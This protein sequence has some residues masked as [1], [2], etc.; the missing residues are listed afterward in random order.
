MSHSTI[1]FGPRDRPLIGAIL[2]ADSSDTLDPDAALVAL[3][4]NEGP[5]LVERVDPD[6]ILIESVA[7]EAG[8]PWA[9]SGEPS[10]ADRGRRLVALVERAH[11]QARPVVIWWHGAVHR[12]PALIPFE[13]LADLVVRAQPGDP[14]GPEL[15][16][17]PGVQLSRFHPI[18]APAERPLHPVFAERWPAGGPYQTRSFAAVVLESARDAGL[19]RWVDADDAHESS[20]IPQVVADL[21]TRRLAS[22]HAA[23]A[24][25]GHGLFLADLVPTGS[26]TAPNERALAQLACGARVVGGSS[27]AGDPDLV[28]TVVPIDQPDAAGEAVRNGVARGSL[29]ATERHTVLRRVFDVYA[30]DFAVS[31]LVRY[32]GLA[33]RRPGRRDVCAVGRLADLEDLAR[34]ADDLA[35]QTHRPVEAAIEAASSQV[36]RSARD[37][38]DRQGVHATITVGQPA[39]GLLDW[40]A[41]H[42]SARWLWPWSRGE[43]AGPTVLADAVIAGLTSGADVVTR[44]AGSGGPTSRREARPGSIIARDIVRRLPA[45]PVGTYLDWEGLGISVYRLDEPPVAEQ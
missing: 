45:E 33:W 15:P 42:A 13:R 23:S 32:L 11:A 29:S 19:E 22:R 26:A 37:E 41:D 4:P 34:F 17:S 38:L 14:A 1:G 43:S 27:L 35:R 7:L 2:T 24:Y 36:G 25:R 18:G 10:S 28:G 6:L 12:T 44:A 16:W 21:P 39:E 5:D 8:Q 30:T 20:A 3:A 40:A 9:F 31:A